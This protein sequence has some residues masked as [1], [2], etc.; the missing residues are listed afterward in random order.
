MSHGGKGS[1][2][3]PAQV[4]KEVFANNWD[5]IFAR[6]EIVE[7]K[8]NPDAYCLRVGCM[9]K[10][11]SCQHGQSWDAL[12][13]LPEEQRKLG[14][15]KMKRVNE[16]L[17]QITFGSLYLNPLENV[18]FRS[19][20]DS[21]KQVGDIVAPVQGHQLHDGSGL[22]GA[23]VVVSVEPYV[24]VSES[25]GMRWSQQKAKDFLVKGKAGKEQ[26]A[27]CMTRLG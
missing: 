23:A 17:C 14:Q 13:E 15:S 21:I 19:L 16:S 8:D 12:N 10:C 18:W 24:M 27:L 7:T 3:R 11:D 9:S 5:A 26:L 2:M 4:S 22:Y 20:R 1:A 25:A 6:K